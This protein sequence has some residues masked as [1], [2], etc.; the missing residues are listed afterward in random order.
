LD[1]APET[2]RAN[3]NLQTLKPIQIPILG[4]NEAVEFTRIYKH[5]HSIKRRIV[6]ADNT[7]FESLSQRAF[8]GEL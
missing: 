4:G 6:H 8:R 7:L 2:A 1:Q 5:I 3:I